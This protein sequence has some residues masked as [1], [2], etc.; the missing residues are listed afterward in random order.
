MNTIKTSPSV[1][2]QSQ[3]ACMMQAHTHKELI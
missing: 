3:P 1:T 2:R